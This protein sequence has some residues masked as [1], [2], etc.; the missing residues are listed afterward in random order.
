[1]TNIIITLA[2]LLSVSYLLYRL[3]KFIISCLE[4]DRPSCLS[5]DDRESLKEL[6]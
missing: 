5:D 3:Y 6:W 2:V 1:M 4:E